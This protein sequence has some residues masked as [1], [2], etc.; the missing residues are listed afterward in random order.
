MRLAVRPWPW[1]M[2]RQ[3]CRPPLLTAVGKK[4]ATPTIPNHPQDP[5]AVEGD[6]LEKE[7]QRLTTGV[8]GVS[9]GAEGASRGSKNG[10]GSADD[11][12]LTHLDLKYRGRRAK[13]ICL[14]DVCFSDDDS[15]T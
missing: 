2:M 10:A 5:F 12:P 11:T 4:I 9:A 14:K 3:T 6:Q 8:H 15:P 13:F 1:F 7:S